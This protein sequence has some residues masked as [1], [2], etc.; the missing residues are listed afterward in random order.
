ML[1]ADFYGK[2]LPTQPDSMT[3]VR[4]MHGEHGILEISPTRRCAARPPQ[5]PTETLARRDAE[6]LMQ[7]ELLSS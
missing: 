4:D 3:I 2:L 7:L 5:M 6:H 1:E